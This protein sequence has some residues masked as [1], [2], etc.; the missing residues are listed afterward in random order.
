MRLLLVSGDAKFNMALDEALLELISS[1]RSEPTVRFYRF[2]P[3][4]VTIGYFQSIRKTVNLQKATSLGIDVVRRPT[5]GGAVL[6]DEK[7]E[8]T[9][10]VVV[11]EISGEEVVESFRRICLGVILTLKELGLEA[12]F[13]PVNDV[14]VS[15]RKISGSA[16][17][18]RGGFILQHGTILYNADLDLMQEVLTP[19]TEKLLEK[20]VSSIRERVTTVSEQLGRD[21]SFDE[22]LDAAIKGFSRALGEKL[23][24]SDPTED[25]LIL[26]SELERK[27]GSKEW[28]E[29]R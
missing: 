15:G 17:T 23:I 3:T 2:S 19:P 8:L 27:Y 24:P 6:H 25:E 7:G 14:V 13:V 12:S 4:A 20:G 26:A 1:G 11:P 9:Y 22:V 29:M 28:N 16:Q 10:S 5:G 21:V 18:R